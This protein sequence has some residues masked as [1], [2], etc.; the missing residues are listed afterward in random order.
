MFV[1]VYFL[2]VLLG[3]S[4]TLMTLR[5]KGHI[6]LMA[7]RCSQVGGG[8]GQGGGGAAARIFVCVSLTLV[9]LKRDWSRQTL[10]PHYYTGMA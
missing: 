3:M 1:A 7:R 5:E 2:L 9:L 10:M 8:Q 6:Q 4:M